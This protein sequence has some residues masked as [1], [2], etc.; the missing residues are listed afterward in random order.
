[1]LGIRFKSL[2][3]NYNP[4][5]GRREGNKQ[6]VKVYSSFLH[7]YVVVWNRMGIVLPSLKQSLAEATMRSVSML[8]RKHLCSAL[9]CSTS[10]R[11]ITHTVTNHEE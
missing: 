8:Q 4:F 9:I 6:L 2:E 11:F 7:K 5:V 3:S 1:M 10:K